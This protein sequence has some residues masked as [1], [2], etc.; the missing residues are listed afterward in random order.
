M[1]GGGFKTAMV[2]LPPSPLRGYGGPGKPDTTFGFE[3]TS[4]ESNW[5]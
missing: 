4:K 1:V 3:T 5:H 2:R